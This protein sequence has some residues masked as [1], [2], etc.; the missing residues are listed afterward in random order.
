MD[1]EE[2]RQRQKLKSHD[3]L[4]SGVIVTQLVRDRF[5]LVTNH[6]QND[7]CSLCDGAAGS[8]AHY[9]SRHGYTKTF[10]PQHKAGAQFTDPE[11]MEG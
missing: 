10:N 5:T 3:N 6:G 2:T 8:P 7:V 4:Y 11:G 1:T 9:S